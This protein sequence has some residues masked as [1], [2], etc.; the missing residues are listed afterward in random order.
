MNAST[1]D[2]S[3]LATNL[4]GSEVLK[5]AGEINA[6]KASGKKIANF[7]VGDFDPQYFPIPERLK[8]LIIEAVGAG[9]TNYPPSSGIPLLREAVAAFYTREFGVATRASDVLI[10]GGA[11]PLIYST[12]SCTLNAGDTV[13][14][15]VPSWNNN[16]YAYLAGA[17]GIKIKA[18]SENNF[19]P[20]PSEIAP[21]LP[22]ARLLCLNSPLNPTG[23]VFKRETLEKI[24]Q[25]VL[26]ENRRRAA[27]GGRSLYVM[28]DQIYWKILHG[29]AQH[30]H[31]LA[32]V[33]ELKPYTI[34]IDG[35]SKYFSGT[36]LRVGWAVL[37]EKL[38]SAFSSFL[39]H[40]GAWAPKP[41]Q[42]ATAQ[43][44]NDEKSIADFSAELRA[45][46]QRRLVPLYEG[47]CKL[48]AEGLPVDAI[49]AEGGIYLSVRI[50]PRPGLETNEKI[51]QAL[52]HEAGIAVV[53]FQAFGLEEESGW[54]RLSVGAVSEADI[55][56]ALE[57][58]ESLFRK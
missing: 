14:Y 17:K 19:M 9:H 5:I 55:P 21:L 52:L 49:R 2:L 31:P 10:A 48:K 51:R 45:R 7:T 11:R 28:F 56:M 4:I 53:P 50:V 43:F 41:E 22:G 44:L 57:R 27:Q 8:G 25:L 39:G 24:C 46:L 3:Q 6:L 34:F 37:P 15:P 38:M 32:L 35:I 18:L 12:F 54:F 42:I 16:H 30:A 47:I 20:S 40:V 29:D 13:L 23:T 1:P 26:E 33:P 58:L 36:G